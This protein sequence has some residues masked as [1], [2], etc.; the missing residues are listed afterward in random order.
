MKKKSLIIFKWPNFLNKYLISKLSNFYDV[1]HLYLTDFKK[2]T[3]TE[4]IGEINKLISAKKISIV[5]F[6]VDFMK[7]IN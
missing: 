2:E 4:I 3:F 5:F 1:E 7:F 6:D